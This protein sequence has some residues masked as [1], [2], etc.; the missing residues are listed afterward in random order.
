MDFKINSNLVM[1][2]GPAIKRRA[3]EVW[4]RE[5]RRSKNGGRSITAR[6]PVGLTFKECLQ[7]TRERRRGVEEVRF[8]IVHPMPARP[9]FFAA[10]R[11]TMARPIT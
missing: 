11:R 5:N 4:G 8:D 9:D 1:K 7:A 3:L 10:E 6:V 2:V